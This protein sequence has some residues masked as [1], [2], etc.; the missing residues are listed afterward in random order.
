MLLI[1][2]L[3]KVTNS[4]IVQGT[5][6]F[7]VVGVGSDE[8]CWNRVP[9]LDEVF[10]QLD[11]GHRRHMDVCDQA[12][13]FDEARGSEEIRRRRESLDVVVQRPHEPS[14]G[15]AKVPIILNDRD[16]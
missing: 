2:R 14:H 4:P 12:G 8:N 6:A 5:G 13:R 16:Q 9:C 1:N 10:V 11:A 7:N 15:V 3:T